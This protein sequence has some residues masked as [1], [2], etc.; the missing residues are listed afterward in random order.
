MAETGERTVWSGIDLAVRAGEWLVVTGANGSGKSTLAGVLL[1]I[2]PLTDGT[3]ERESDCVVRGVLQQ[4]DAQ[5]VSD[6]IEEEFAYVEEAAGLAK[7]GRRRF[8]VMALE[9]VG[10]SVQPERAFAGLSGGQK[11]LVNIAVALAGKPDVLVLDEPTA[12]LDPAGRQA[13]LEAVGRANDRGTAVVWITHR[14]EDAA[15]ADRLVAFAGGFVAFEGTPQAFFYGD[16]ADGMVCDDDDGEQTGVKAGEAPTSEAASG[17]VGAPVAP[18]DRLGLQ[19]PYVVRS[20][21]L[22]LKRGYRLRPLPLRA[23][24]LAEAVRALCL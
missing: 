8:C 17:D 16:S 13:V 20:A 23:D 2:F 22:L 19:A 9:A 6:T 12:M 7:E 11:Q 21:T 4:P 14:L 10:L 18:C 15:Y 5:F 1:G 24:E 3:F